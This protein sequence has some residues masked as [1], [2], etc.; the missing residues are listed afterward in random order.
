[1]QLARQDRRAVTYTKRAISKRWMRSTTVEAAACACRARYRLRIQYDMHWLH[2]L[3]HAYVRL[4]VRGCVHTYVVLACICYVCSSLHIV[5]WPAKT[6]HERHKGSA[7]RGA[8]AVLAEAGR[9]GQQHQAAP[10]LGG[11]CDT[12]WTRY[13]VLHVI[14]TDALCWVCLLKPR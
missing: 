11:W 12:Y 5:Q 3:T 13:V 10:R 8:D 6:V 9:R 1:M 14:C 4:C 7:W 2:L